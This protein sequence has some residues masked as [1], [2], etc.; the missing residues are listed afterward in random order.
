MPLL[1]AGVGGDERSKIGATGTA[2]VLTL[3]EPMSNCSTWFLLLLVDGAAIRSI[4]PDLYSFR[5]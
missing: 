3:I 1:A 4:P 5:F 2:V